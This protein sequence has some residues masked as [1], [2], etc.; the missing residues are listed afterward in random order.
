MTYKKEP[1]VDEYIRTLPDWQRGICQRI[2]DLIHE[3]DPGITET[4]KWDTPVFTH[5]GN[6]CAVG[7]FRDHVKVNFF[8]GAALPDP[9]GLFNAGLDAKTSRA[10]DL[11]EG[12]EIDENAF[13]ALVQAAVAAAM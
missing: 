3:A 7:A 8:K 12:A 5:G 6:V 1:R 2:R 4:W 10:I 9:N 13:R 11:R